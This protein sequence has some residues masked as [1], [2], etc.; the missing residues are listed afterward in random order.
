[1]QSPL[2]K[3][4]L[5]IVYSDG[6]VADKFL[7]GI[8]YSLRFMGLKVAGLVQRNTFERDSAKCDMIVE[9]LLSSAILQISED[10]GRSA[11]GCRLNRSALLEATTRLIQALSE[12]PDVLILNKFGKV[13]AEGGGLRDVMAIAVENDIPIIVGVPMRNIEQWRVFAEGLAQECPVDSAYVR[14]WLL[15]RKILPESW[16]QRIPHSIVS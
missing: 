10:R 7:A 2:S 16:R 11:R 6:I 13:E 4:I 12:K 8:G 3:P 5:A 14:R 1:M 15:M 9:E